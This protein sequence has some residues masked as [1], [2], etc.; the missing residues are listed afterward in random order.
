MR[1]PHWKSA[2]GSLLCCLRSQKPQRGPLALPRL[3]PR[4]SPGLGAPGDRKAAHLSHRG[5]DR[6]EPS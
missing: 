6:G 4:R 5:K 2:L 1:E 3:I